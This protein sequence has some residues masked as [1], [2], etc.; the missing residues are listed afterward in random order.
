MTTFELETCLRFDVQL[1]NSMGVATRIHKFLD[2][3]G[4]APL[5][6]SSAGQVVASL[7]KPSPDR[8]LIT[9]NKILGFAA[10]RSRLCNEKLVFFVA[11]KEAEKRVF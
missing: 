10:P 2:I 6:V 1:A 4:T 11:Q 7:N 5:C 3:C 9:V 8:P